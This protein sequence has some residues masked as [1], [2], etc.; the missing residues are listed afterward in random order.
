[1]F[2]I[3]DPGHICNEYLVL[4]AKSGMTG[5]SFSHGQWICS[6]LLTTSERLLCMV[7]ARRKRTSDVCGLVRKA[8]VSCVSAFPL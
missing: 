2:G 4:L 1:V 6:T 3:N 7:S 8:C 5:S